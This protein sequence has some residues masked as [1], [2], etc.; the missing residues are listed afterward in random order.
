VENPHDLR[1]EGVFDPS[2]S[3]TATIRRTVIIFKVCGEVVPPYK[4]YGKKSSF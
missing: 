3:L 1:I 4:V 2:K